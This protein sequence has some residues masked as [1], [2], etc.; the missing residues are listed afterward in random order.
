MTTQILLKFFQSLDGSLVDTRFMAMAPLAHAGF[1]RF[2]ELS[3]LRP[4]DIIPHQTYVEL[5]IESSKT[6]QYRESAAVPIVKT[7]TALFPRANL[8]K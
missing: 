7:S 5:F 4:K 3:N 2:D 8:V 1:L 6:D